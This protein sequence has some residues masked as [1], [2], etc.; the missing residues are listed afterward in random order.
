LARTFLWLGNGAIAWAI[1]FV[2]ARAYTT[3][4]GHSGAAIVFLYP[5]LA[6]AMLA[7]ALYRNGLLA[8]IGVALGVWGA[9]ATPYLAWTNVLRDYEDW[10]RAGMPVPP[11]PDHQ[12]RVVLL[13]AGLCIVSL[14][15]ICAHASRRKTR[16][17]G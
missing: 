14:A 10:I 7:L 8:R 4:S 1:V 17:A 13:Y 2:L 11:T 5:C 16:T 15:V 12:Q 3:D 9:L 6:W